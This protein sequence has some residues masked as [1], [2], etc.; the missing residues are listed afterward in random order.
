MGQFSRSSVLRV[1]RCS[2]LFKGVGV[3]MVLLCTV[4]NVHYIMRIAY[5]LVYAMFAITPF[6]GDK[7]EMPWIKCG[8]G[9]GFRWGMMVKVSDLL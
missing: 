2:P 4:T 9:L 6:F 1:W 7:F 5:A 8:E 3:S